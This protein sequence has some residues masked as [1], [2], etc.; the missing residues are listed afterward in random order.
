LLN[1]PNGDKENP[2]YETLE[3]EKLIRLRAPT[4]QKVFFLI[5]FACCRESPRFKKD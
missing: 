2:Y 4:M 5:L 3:V 1:E